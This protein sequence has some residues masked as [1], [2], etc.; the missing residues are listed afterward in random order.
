MKNWRSHTLSQFRN[1]IENGI[2]RGSRRMTA[3]N[4]GYVDRAGF[5]EGQR[6]RAGSIGGPT[7]R[8]ADETLPRRPNLFPSTTTTTDEGGAQFLRAMG[9]S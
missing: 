8:G 6:G 4:P 9:K 7:V 5:P 1:D 3:K 2:A